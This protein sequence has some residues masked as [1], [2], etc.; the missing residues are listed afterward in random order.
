MQSESHPE[1]A[2]LTDVSGRLGRN[3]LLVQAA[4]GNT[5]VK[6]DGVLWIKASG[7]WLA[8]AGQEEMFVP[9]DLEEMRAGVA[10]GLD[11]AR[12]RSSAC[13]NLRPSIE[14][15]MHA[16]IPHRVT[17]HVHSVNAIAWAVRKD[18]RERCAE[19]L[20]GL[21]WQWIPYVSSGLPLAREAQK[22]LTRSPR[23][24]VLVL[25]NHGL[26]VCGDDVLAAEELLMEVEKRL[27]IQPRETSEPSA[28]LLEQ[29]ILG[30]DW[31]LPDR[32]VVH[33]LG[34]D[35]I[36]RAILQAGVLYP[37]Q[38]IFLGPR[39][40]MWPVSMPPTREV[41]GQLR[42]ATAPGF[43]VVEDRGVILSKALNGAAR[44]M[45]HGL[46]EVIQRL[47]NQAN[48]RYLTGAELELVMNEDAHHYRGLVEQAGRR[49]HR[50]S[51]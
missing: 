27:H 20:A 14:T 22:S 5:S 9:V 1:I 2:V 34:T 51:A 35:A 38:A 43:I 41:R 49:A 6:L 37:C 42:Q 21:E 46:A 47:D 33:A 36:S 32:D 11:L 50:A 44:E 18:G 24:Q 39:V 3:P 30:S 13:Q 4:S 10:R 28:A 40:P 23:A 29:V 48:L 25:A 45:L 16:V 31:R 8:R 17:I 26:V 19:R 12:V 15:A 7:K